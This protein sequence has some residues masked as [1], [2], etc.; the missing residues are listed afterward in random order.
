MINGGRSKSPLNAYKVRSRLVHGGEVKPIKQ[1]SGPDLT[2]PELVEVAEGLL[3]GAL[4][5][6][7]SLASESKSRWVVDWEGHLLKSME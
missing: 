2:P 7:V 5:K 1:E 6:A 3:R 4:R